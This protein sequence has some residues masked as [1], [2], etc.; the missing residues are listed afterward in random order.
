MI[1]PYFR[2]FIN[3]HKPTVKL[4]NTNSNNKTNNS[5]NEKNDGAEG[6]NQLV[7]PNKFI[8]DENFEDTRTIKFLIQF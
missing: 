2:D 1:R 5:N 8:Y 7:M 6:K 3:E 4:N